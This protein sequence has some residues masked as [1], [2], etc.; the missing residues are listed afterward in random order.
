MMKIS[1]YAVKTY[2]ATGGGWT[3]RVGHM[4]NLYDFDLIVFPQKTE[5]QIFLNFTDM[6]SGNHVYSLPLSPID[7]F[8]TGIKERCLV[9]FQEKASVIKEIIDETGID[10]F[11]KKSIEALKNNE[12]R[13]GIKPVT[14][15]YQNI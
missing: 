6:K 9:M 4:I 10:N 14:E 3:P 11:S 13:F 12:E 5:S 15:I 1:D 8:E 2:I 7:F